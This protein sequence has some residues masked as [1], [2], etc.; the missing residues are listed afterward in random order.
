[1]AGL[2]DYLTGSANIEGID[3]GFNQRLYR[4][5]Q[6]LP[7]ELAQEVR[8][9]SAY[10]SVEEQADLYRKAINDYGSEAAARKWVAPPGKSNH[11]HG[12]A[13][14]L[15]Y[16]SPAAKKWMHDNAEKF[17]LSFPMAHEDWHIEPI[18]VRS[19]EYNG[20]DISGEA[21]TDGMGLTPAD[22]RSTET[23]LLRLVNM[24]SNGT[25]NMARFR[26]G[27]DTDIIDAVERNT[28]ITDG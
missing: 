4:M 14:D 17:G 1:M 21:Y 12:V 13:I 20:L 15:R 5:L 22:N 7:P 28:E 18:G 11:N 10:R 2:E 6:A 26:S 23:Q 16:G 8:A 27:A 25:E 3:D 19:G 24:V 9:F